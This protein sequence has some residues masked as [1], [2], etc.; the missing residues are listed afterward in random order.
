MISRSSGTAAALITTIAAF[1]IANSVVFTA[2]ASGGAGPRALVSFPAMAQNQNSIANAI[3]GASPSQ[4][5]IT[6]YNSLADSAYPAMPDVLLVHSN[7]TMV[8]YNASADTD[9]ARGAALGSADRHLA[10]GDSIYLKAETYNVVAE[11]GFSMGGGSGLATDTRLYGAGVGKT[12]IVGYQSLPFGPGINSIVSDLSVFGMDYQQLRWHTNY[13]NDIVRNVNWDQIGSIDVIY[14]MATPAWGNVIF[15]NDTLTS[16]WDT[17]N[18]GA[19]GT[20]SGNLIL[21]N[22]HLNPIVNDS[23]NQNPTFTARGAGVYTGTLILVNTTISVGSGGYTCPA[24]SNNAGCLGVDVGGGTVNIYGGFITTVN[25]LTGT[26]YSIYVASGTAQTN[27]LAA[28]GTTSGTITSVGSQSFS[29]YAPYSYPTS[30]VSWPLNSVVSYTQNTAWGTGTFTANVIVQDSAA[31]QNLVYNS[32]TYNVLAAPTFVAAPILWSTVTS[33]SGASPIS[34]TLPAGYAGYFWA[35]ASKAVGSSASSASGNWLS[36]AAVGF[37]LGST[38]AK[39]WNASGIGHNTILSGV[40]TF[41]GTANSLDGGSLVGYAA[42]VLYR[43]MQYGSPFFINGNAPSNTLV[44]SVTAQNSFVILAFASGSNTL[45][46][47]STNAPNGYTAVNAISPNSIA[48]TVIM[49]MNNLAAGSY[50]A[51]ASVSATHGSAISIAA[52]VWSPYNVVLNNNALSTIGFSGT[53]FATNSMVVALGWANIVANPN[54]GY[55]FSNWVSSD[56]TNIIV[57]NTLSASTNVII[58]GP[59]IV[60]AT[61]N[62]LLMTPTLTSSP[63]LS[64]TMDVNTPI[65]FTASGIGGGTRGS[66][67]TLNYILSNTVTNAVITFQ[68]FTSVTTT[69]NSFTWSIPISALGNTIAANVFVTDQAGSPATVNTVDYQT[70]TINNAI[71]L[72]TLTSS[73][74]LS[75]TLDANTLITFTASNIGGGTKGS[76]YTLNY[77]MS[78]TVTNAVIASQL[79]SGVTTTTNSFTWSILG[80]AIGSTVAANVIVTDQAAIPTSANSVDYQTLSVNPDLFS[81]FWTASNSPISTGSVQVLTANL[82][83]G[84]SPYSFNI[85]VYNALGTLEYSSLSPFTSATSN[86]VSFTQQSSWN[87]G[88]FTANVYITDNELGGVGAYDVANSIQYTI[89]GGAALTISS[90]TVSNSPIYANQLQVLTAGITGGTSPFSFNVVVYNALGVLKYSS[91]SPFAG[92]TSNIVTFIQQQ[93]WQA[94]SFTAN[95]YVTDSTPGA[96]GANTVGATASYT[97]SLATVCYITLTNSIVNFGPINANANVPTQNVITDMDTGGTAAATILIA[98][99]IGNSNTWYDNSIWL[100]TSGSNTIGIANTVWSAS[101]NTAWASGTKL[102]NSLSSTGIIVQNPNGITATSNNVYLGMG[103]PAAQKKDIYTTN[104]VIE[105]SC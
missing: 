84:T 65:T 92:A 51:F 94:G 26:P 25:A 23:I 105:N 89:S 2:G 45:K 82:V 46:A 10:T 86:V 98:G 66:G 87:G 52:Y 99:G 41:T 42:N 79:F 91:V 61:Y 50:N 49:T 14:L 60:T 4:S 40:W 80:S 36:D 97:A 20:F 33:N 37:T 67:Y 27:Y 43:K 74:L 71:Y 3:G 11:A 12:R 75:N 5:N 73:P 15:Y 32:L 85:L 35:G 69:S 96:P 34:N 88:T 29:Q 57:Q 64:A 1:C 100:G 31:Q 55:T 78:N 95:V 7:G 72:P 76:G 13:G 19:Q 62:A 83:G 30:P 24:A 8:G 53:N 63:A 103:V 68:R 104:I 70:L 22:S 58:E 18:L 90:W 17:I 59:G 101:L 48:Q 9:Q 16:G 44:F 77:I 21:I 38:G 102:S 54:T 93:S 39:R 81:T 47:Y 6:V 28:Y 56:P